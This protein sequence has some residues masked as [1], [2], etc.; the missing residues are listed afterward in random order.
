LGKRRDVKEAHYKDI[1]NHQKKII[2]KLRKQVSRATKLGE[3]FFEE[4]TDFEFDEVE[5]SK[6]QQSKNVCPRC[7]SPLDVIDGTRMKVYICTGCDY[8][9]SKKGST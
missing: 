5:S 6:P 3:Q 2:Q 8:R 4:E 9:A 1:I 7:G